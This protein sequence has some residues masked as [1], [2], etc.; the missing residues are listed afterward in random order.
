[1][2]R[3]NVKHLQIGDRVGFS[4]S[5]VHATGVIAEDLGPD[6]VKVQWSDCQVAT[7]HRRHAL[8]FEPVTV[9]TGWARIAFADARSQ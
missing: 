3:R 5:S 6:Y 9:A 7:T 8:E 4:Q 1:L 2:T